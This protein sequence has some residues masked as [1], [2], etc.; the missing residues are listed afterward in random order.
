MT[1]IVI[2]SH[3]QI[4]HHATVGGLIR[5][6]AHHAHAPR[7]APSTADCSSSFG[8]IF[9]SALE[10]SACEKEFWLRW[11]RHSFAS[12]ARRRN[13]SGVLSSSCKPAPP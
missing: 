8:D 3:A 9:S 2:I 1:N 5:T 10:K 12:F 13:L 11:S 7:L 4:V 6:R